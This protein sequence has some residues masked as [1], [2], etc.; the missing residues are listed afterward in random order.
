MSRF[1]DLLIGTSLLAIM[2]LLAMAEPLG[3]GRPALP[4]EIAAWDVNVMP[5]GRGLPEGQG[6]AADG[7]LIFSDNCAACHGEFAEGVGN[8]PQLAGGFDTLDRAD[9]VK[10]VGSYWPY[11][12]TVWDYIHRSM[13]YGNAQSLSV[14][15]TYAIVAYIL[16]SNFLVDEDFVL[17]R[18]SFGEVEMPNVGGF[19]ADDRDAVELPKFIRDPCM[20]NCKDSVEITMRAA[21]LDVTPDDASDNPPGEDASAGM[22]EGGGTAAPANGV[23]V[24]EGAPKQVPA[25]GAEGI[26]PEAEAEAQPKP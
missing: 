23:G 19:I 3:L 14:D 1:R 10:T 21:N 12:S 20:E 15:D 4:E 17:S 7:E 16:Y 8:W 5:D 24:S 6:S 25:E 18:E 9:P 2:P 22:L 26:A 11:L 13:P